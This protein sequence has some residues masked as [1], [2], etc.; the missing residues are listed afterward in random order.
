MAEQERALKAEQESRRKLDI[1]QVAS[2]RDVHRGGAVQLV[3]LAEELKRRGHRVTCVFN[4]PSDNIDLRAFQVLRSQG[5]D[6]VGFDLDGRGEKKRFRRWVQQRDFEILHAHRDEALV[7]SCQALFGLRRPLIAAGRGTCYRLKSFTWPWLFFRSGKVRR[8]IAVAEA[9]KESLLHCGVKE[10]K[11][12]VVYGSVE[13]EDFHPEADGLM[14]RTVWSG[15]EKVNLVGNV[16][17]LVAKKG[18][19]IF[20]RAAQLVRRSIPQCRFVCVGRGKPEKYLPLLKELDLTEAVV[21]ANH[22]HDMP[23]AMCALD[24]VVSSATKGEGL[25]GAVRE[26]MSCARPVVATDV[27]G[28]GEIVQDG[29]NGRLVPARDDQALAKAIIELLQDSERARQLGLAGRQTVLERFTNQQRGERM[30]HLYLAM[31]EESGLT[32]IT[33]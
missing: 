24:V 4:R 20:F 21:F 1:L 2:H 14:L 28:N 29:H 10:Q 9:V 30:E 33:A 6:V 5:I 22:R 19:D 32:T 12:K 26:A 15:G 3:R 8:V 25:T 27:A 11:I 13:E 18:Y 31:A 16:A 17:A 7:F 23:Q